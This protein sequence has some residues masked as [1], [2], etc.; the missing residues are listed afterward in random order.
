MKR[1]SELI[2]ER[3]ILSFFVIVFV[4][5]WGLGFSYNAVLN[6]DTVILIPL[7]SI[8]TCGPAIAGIIIARV[9]AGRQKVGRRKSQ[10]IAFA[11]ALILGTAVFTINNLVVEQNEISIG[12][13]AAI[14]VLFVSPV[15]W[16]ISTAFARRAALRNY[17]TTL[18]RVRG[19]FWWCVVAAALLPVLVLLSVVMQSVI[20]G[21]PLRQPENGV[22]GM[23]VIGTIVAK[24]VYQLF[25]FNV[26]GEEIGWSGF[27]RARL[28]KRFS[29]LL[30]GLI[31]ALFWAPW[32]LF[33][34]HAEG[35]QIAT[36]GF[37]FNA[38]L[39]VVPISILIGWLYNR[40]KGSILVAGI[41]HAAGN[42]AI[43]LIPN[44]SLRAASAVT[45][46]A[47]V[48]VIIVDRM[49]KKLPQDQ[50]S[51]VG[52]SKRFSRES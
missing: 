37:W 48:I 32:H 41:A 12:T 34:W 14:A 29:P 8:A 20:D 38:Y 3:P 51:G 6:R 35:E 42:T 49:W 7:V 45:A 2:R 36:I 17:L 44:V 24:F 19:V 39:T 10:W 46:V 5:T 30:T 31:V 43:A 27:A 4:I 26:V 9:T 47:T 1:V 11:V 13:V 23:S 15:A 22:V 33:L 16:V 40:S 28:Q 18:M 21:Y 25:F 52:N 50:N